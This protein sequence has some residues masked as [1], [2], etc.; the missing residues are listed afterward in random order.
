ME[1]LLFVVIALVVLIIGAA[2]G[3]SST[4]N[5]IEKEGYKVLYSADKKA[6][7]G[8]YALIDIRELLAK[9]AQRM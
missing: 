4:I 3:R 9:K 8:R 1:I 2:I 6:G 7:E 5:A